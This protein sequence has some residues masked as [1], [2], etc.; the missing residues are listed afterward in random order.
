MG[1]GQALS[2][3][4]SQINKSLY[5]CKTFGIYSYYLIHFFIRHSCYWSI[6]LLDI[7]AIKMKKHRMNIYLGTEFEMTD[8]HTNY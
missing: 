8:L 7:I 4:H 2:A 5:K 1:E 3:K 6:I